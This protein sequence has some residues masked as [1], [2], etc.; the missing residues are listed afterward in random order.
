MK[1]KVTKECIVMQDSIELVKL[2][3]SKNQ[4]AIKIVNICMT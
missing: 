1:K 3:L 2:G 4:I